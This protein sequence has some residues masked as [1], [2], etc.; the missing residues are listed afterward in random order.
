MKWQMT[1][2]GPDD[3]H[4]ASSIL[5]AVDAGCV[6]CSAGSVGIVVNDMLFKLC[7]GQLFIYPPYAKI[8]IASPSPDFECTVFDVDHQFLLNTLKAVSWS[9]NLH[10]ISDN[11]IATPSR[12]HSDRLYRLLDL[13][14]SAESAGEHMEALSVECLK[15]SFTYEVLAAFTEQMTAPPEVKSSKDSIVLEFQAMLKRECLRHRCVG[16]YASVQGLTPRYFTTVIRE[17]TGKTA[18]YWIINAVIVEAQHLMLD[19]SISLKEITFRL[20][21]S[22]QTFFS[23][24]YKQYT[25][26]TPTQFRKRNRI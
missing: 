3:S 21:F 22:S 7:K 6:L 16:Y 12:Y 20:N 15:Q 5:K 18:S 25:G 24:W 1:S 2:I 13:L 17:M 23:R 10:L 4:T 14:T 11:P 9:N 8:D 19:Y 26:E